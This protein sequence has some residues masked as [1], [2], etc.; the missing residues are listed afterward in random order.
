M[1]WAVGIF[2]GF[3]MAFFTQVFFMT[4]FGVNLLFPNVGGD[5]FLE[6][7]LFYGPLIAIGVWIVVCIAVVAIWALWEKDKR[8]K[9][10]S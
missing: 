6:V 7:G 4:D 8:K 2:V 9:D 10:N 5:V 3:V 1:K